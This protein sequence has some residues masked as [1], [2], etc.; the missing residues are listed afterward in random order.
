MREMDI[1][2]SSNGNTGKGRGK[3]YFRA[4]RIRV[5]RKRIRDCKSRMIEHECPGKLAKTPPFRSRFTCNP[6]KLYAD[7]EYN[8]KKV[9]YT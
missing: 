9:I 2:V 5:I 1:P 7:R 4:Q 3:A 6:R 8:L